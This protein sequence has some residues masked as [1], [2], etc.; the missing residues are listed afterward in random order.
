MKKRF[1]SFLFLFPVLLLSANTGDTLNRYNAAK[2][3]DGYW[4]VYLDTLLKPV[5]SAQ[6]FFYGY[7]HYDN[8][9]VLFSFSRFPLEIP[10]KYSFGSDAEHGEKGKPVLLNGSF[11]VYYPQGWKYQEQLFKDGRPVQ[12]RNMIHEKNDPDIAYS[13]TLYFDQLYNGQAGSY[14]YEEKE[15]GAATVTGY[16][17]KGE[18]GWQAYPEK[19]E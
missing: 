2:K 4:L 3:K 18:K 1:L 11:R 5:D 14:Y 8:G 16:F 9:E 6:A 7:E 12:I 19:T 17:R 15:Q 13:Q 10:K